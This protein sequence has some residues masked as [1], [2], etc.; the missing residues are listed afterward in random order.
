MVSPL[1]TASRSRRSLTSRARPE[2]NRGRVHGHVGA[3]ARRRLCAHEVHEGARRPLGACLLRPAMRRHAL[4]GQPRE[5]ARQRAL[6]LL[7]PPWRYGVQNTVER[8]DVLAPHLSKSRKCEQ[9][10]ISR[11]TRYACCNTLCTVPRVCSPQPNLLTNLLISRR[12]R[13]AELVQSIVSSKGIA[14]PSS[15][16]TGMQPGSR[17]LGDFER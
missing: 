10:G 6:H 7:D 17:Q 15:K 12:T 14:S 2:R 8:W 4:V 1:Q 9:K 5:R 3:G 11:S 13:T 16:K